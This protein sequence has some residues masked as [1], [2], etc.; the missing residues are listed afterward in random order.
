M[1]NVKE[2]KGITVG[3]HNVNTLRYADNT[4]LV[5]ENKEHFQ[6]IESREKGLELNIKKTKVMVVSRN[7][8]CPQILFINL[9]KL[10]QRDQIEYLGNLI[11]SDGPL[12]L[13]R[14]N[15]L[16]VLVF[17]CETSV[18]SIFSP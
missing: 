17:K 2:H 11:S 13:L 14:T 3:K 10:I 6:Q 1:Q 16:V 12:E 15:L 9:N 7:N 8:D 4:E 18:R 5:A